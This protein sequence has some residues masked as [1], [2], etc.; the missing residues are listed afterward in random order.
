MT[1]IGRDQVNMI[2]VHIKDIIPTDTTLQLIN[3]AI[4]LLR[5]E[6]FRTTTPDS[7]L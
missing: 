6:S 5:E 7:E 1:I 2:R 3:F 4:N